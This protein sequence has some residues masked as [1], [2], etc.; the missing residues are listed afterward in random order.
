MFRVHCV[1]IHFGKSYSSN[2]ASVSSS[3]EKKKKR[4]KCISTDF[5]PINKRFCT[6]LIFFFM[7]MK[8]PHKTI[9][10]KWSRILYLVS[11]FSCFLSKSVVF[12]FVSHDM[13]FV[14]Q[15]F[16]MLQFLMGQFQLLLIVLVLLHFC[17]KVFKFLLNEISKLAMQ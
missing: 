12:L 4:R 1:A 3:K 2:P 16:H 17:F 6:T 8:K 15:G 7:T 13:F 9:T 5:K 11:H 14:S 10:K